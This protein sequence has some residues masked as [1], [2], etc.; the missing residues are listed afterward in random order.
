MSL[1]RNPNQEDLRVRRTQKMLQNAFVELVIEKG[2]EAITVQMLADRAMINRATFYRHYEDKFDLAEKV[3]CALN[4]EY[5]ASLANVRES[6]PLQGWVM[7]FSHINRY[8]ELYLALLSGMPHFQEYVRE[9]IE[10]ELH[11]ALLQMG[12][13]AEGAALPVPLALRYMASAQMGII[14]WWLEGGQTIPAQQMAEHLMELHNYGPLQPL[15]LSAGMTWN[16]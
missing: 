7:L 13:I 11:A 10:Q 8:A 15:R 6:D 14:Q 3:Y 12:L 16:G 2:F 4:M 9:S 5:R 1:S